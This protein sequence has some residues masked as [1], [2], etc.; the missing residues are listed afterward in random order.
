M[1]ATRVDFGT[2]NTMDATSVNKTMALNAT[3]A[4]LDILYLDGTLPLEGV[5]CDEDSFTLMVDEA[6]AMN[7][8]NIFTDEAKGYTSIAGGLLN[9]TACLDAPPSSNPTESA[10]PGSYTLDITGPISIMGNGSTVGVHIP[11]ARTDDWLE[12]IGVTLR[13]TSDPDIVNA[14]LSEVG[15]GNE[16]NNETL[17][18]VASDNAA[19]LHSNLGGVGP[20]EGDEELSLKYMG[21]KDG[22]SLGINVTVV[23]GTYTTSQPNL[24]GLTGELGQVH[25]E[26]NATSDS[27]VTLQFCLIDMETGAL[28][29]NLDEFILAFIDMEAVNGEGG[30]GVQ[31][32]T[33]SDFD[34]FY[35]QES[36]SIV[37]EN[38]TEGAW[39]FFATAPVADDDPDDLAA[40]T[41]AQLEKTLMLLVVGQ[42]CVEVTLDL[43]AT[44]ETLPFK[45]SIATFTDFNTYGDVSLPELTDLGAGGMRKLL[46][47]ETVGEFIDDTAEVVTD[48]I[49]FV[50]CDAIGGLVGR[51]SDEAKEC[52]CDLGM[53]IHMELWPVQRPDR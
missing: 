50:W 7:V 17:L 5:E 45:F 41:E 40:A 1:A 10:I 3:F 34:D 49:D 24:N 52:I 2:N 48:V 12:N 11:T 47:F 35:L 36:S 46:F 16:T 18:L 15:V 37:A 9:V 27:S 38:G 30:E 19:L 51:L 43:T 39:T 44:S 13:K 32:I 8:S 23:N 4:V 21:F 25:V 20:D 14:L 53:L 42:P 26:A 33:S 31:S 29:T 28:A 6:L 22:Q